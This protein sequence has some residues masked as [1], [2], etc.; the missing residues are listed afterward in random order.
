MNRNMF[1]HKFLWPRVHKMRAATYGIKFTKV[2]HSP[3]GRCVVRAYFY[4]WHMMDSR[5]LE[6]LR[7]R[8]LADYYTVVIE[9]G[10]TKVSFYCSPHNFLW[11][12]LKCSFC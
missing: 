8:I 2:D 10:I 6:K 9:K 3:S 11:K 7:K 1:V 4:P 5:Q 12:W